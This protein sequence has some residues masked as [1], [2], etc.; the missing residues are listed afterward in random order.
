MRKG[1]VV[2]GGVRAG[3]GQGWGEARGRDWGW[4]QG[5]SSGVGRLER[6]GTRGKVTSLA[7][8]SYLECGMR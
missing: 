7:G 6:A 2:E 4:E 1:A 3:P 8:L 5:G